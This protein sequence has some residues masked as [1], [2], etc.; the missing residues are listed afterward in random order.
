MKLVRSMAYLLHTI[1]SLIMVAF[2][3]EEIRMFV[4]KQVIACLRSVVHTLLTLG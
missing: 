4:L 3:D 2:I 1:I